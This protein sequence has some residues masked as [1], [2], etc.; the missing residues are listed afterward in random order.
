MEGACVLDRGPQCTQVHSGGR[1]V[2]P[3][4]VTSSLGYN[5]RIYKIAQV[6]TGGVD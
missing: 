5:Y 6:Q 3:R 2:H 1:L 4:A